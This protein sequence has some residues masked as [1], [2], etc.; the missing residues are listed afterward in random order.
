MSN[1]QPQ[2]D[3]VTMD[4][5]LRDGARARVRVLRPGDT[6][7]L[8]KFVG[9]L[10]EDSIYYRFLTSGISREALI[11]EL[12]PRTGCLSLVAIMDGRI[13]G[14]SSYC[15][16]GPE[17]AE[18]GLLILDEYQGRGLGTGLTERIARAANEDGV[19]MFEAIIDWNNTRM[20]ELVRNLGFPTSEK[21]EPELIRIRFPTSID[22]VTIAEFQERWL[23]RP[24]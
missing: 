17:A 16:S 6:A 8:E 3:S 12:S 14:L 2:R 13:V 10:S 24:A 1:L 11:S 19:S 5:A 23:F 7:E 4:L 21:V 18:V 15:R 9:G 22:P 20:I